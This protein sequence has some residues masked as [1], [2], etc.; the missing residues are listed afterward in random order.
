MKYLFCFFLSARECMTKIR[1]AIR[2]SGY[3][4][5]NCILS[6]LQDKLFRSL[7]KLFARYILVHLPCSSY[8]NHPAYQKN[9]LKTELLYILISVCISANYAHSGYFFLISVLSL[10]VFWEVLLPFEVLRSMPE[11]IID[12][13]VCTCQLVNLNCSYP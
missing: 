1:N 12:Y 5:S 11:P 2:K 9:V 10:T 13:C 3:H 7:L 6:H 8:L 4:A